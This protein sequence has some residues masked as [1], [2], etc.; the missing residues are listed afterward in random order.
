MGVN[1]V[2]EK[3]EVIGLMQQSVNDATKKGVGVNPKK[4]LACLC[5]DYGFSL[6]RLESYLKVLI[7]SESIYTKG[8][9]LYGRED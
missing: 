4:L 7:N 1:W 5:M 8:G 6:A 9:L 3:R 2:H